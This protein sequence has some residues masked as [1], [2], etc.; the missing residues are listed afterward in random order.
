MLAMR[1]WII[2]AALA[3]VAVIAAVA[4]HMQMSDV[5]DADYVRFFDMPA[6]RGVWYNASG[7]PVWVE[8]RGRVVVFYLWLNTTSCSSYTIYDPATA[9]EYRLNASGV[10]KYME[11]RQVNATL[12]KIVYKAPVYGE[13][14]VEI[15]CKKPGTSYTYVS[16]KFP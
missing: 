16:V 3:A 7:Y 12:Y 1:R 4:V 10:Y 8:F 13:W 6:E 14:W 9:Q 11:I 2:P 5:Y 15:E